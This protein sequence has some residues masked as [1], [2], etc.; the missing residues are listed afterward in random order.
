LREAQSRTRLAFS[1]RDKDNYPYVFADW[2]QETVPSETL[3]TSSA[4]PFLVEDFTT[5]LK[6]FSNFLDGR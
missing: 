2:S 1:Q 6:L 3:K 4:V 5:A